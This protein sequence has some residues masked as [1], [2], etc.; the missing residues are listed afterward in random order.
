MSN[1]KLESKIALVTAQIKQRAGALVRK[2]AF[3]IEGRAKASMA[4]PKHGRIYKR[5][6]KEHQASAP[7]EAP[8][9]DEGALVNS[10]KTEITGETS[11]VVGASQE[12]AVNLELG[13]IHVAPRPFL[14]PAFEAEE[15]DFQKG[16][17]ELIK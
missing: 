1:F 4:E 10:I 16:M 13:T 2:T 8:A 3:S 7:S 6:R 14:G 11:A 15:A 12:T 17:K 5:G 9:I